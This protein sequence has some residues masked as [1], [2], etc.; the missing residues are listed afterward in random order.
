MRFIPKFIWKDKPDLTTPVHASDII[1]WEKGIDAANRPAFASP[2]QEAYWLDALAGS[3]QYGLKAKIFSLGDSFTSPAYEPFGWTTQAASRLGQENVIDDYSWCGTRSPKLS[4]EVTG[5]QHSYADN[6]GF[7][8]HLV[9]LNYVDGTD[10]DGQIKLEVW[11]QEL[12]IYYWRLNDYPNPGDIYYSVPEYSKDG[13][14]RQVLPNPENVS[15]NLWKSHIEDWSG[16]VLRLFPQDLG[17]KH[18]LI[19]EITPGRGSFR[20]RGIQWLNLAWPGVTSTWVNNLMDHYSL[21]DEIHGFAADLLHIGTG[22]NELEQGVPIE[23]MKQNIRDIYAKYKT[24]TGNPNVALLTTTMPY[25]DVNYPD[26]AQWDQYFDA[27]VDVT[28]ELGGMCIDMRKL[29]PKQSDGPGLR[30]PGDYHYSV[31]GHTL[32]AAIVAWALRL[33]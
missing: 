4:A 29:F 16:G 22:G 9:Q 25:C 13:G 12:T 11:T 5:D 32:K 30:A 15:G 23:T 2:A 21:Q 27:V 33:K 1:R 26:L 24:K 8:P 3:N 7:N 19:S 20:Y 6:E 31:S 28:A 14:A 18:A 10:N 17:L